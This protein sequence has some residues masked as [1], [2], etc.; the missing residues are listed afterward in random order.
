MGAICS[1]CNQDKNSEVNVIVQPT[2][3][4][5]NIK[6]EFLLSYLNSDSDSDPLPIL[7]LP[8]L[9][10]PTSFRSQGTQK[11]VKTSKR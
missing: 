11:A 8:P 6:D 9:S 1:C 2:A 4:E 3:F 10:D 7:S 5:T